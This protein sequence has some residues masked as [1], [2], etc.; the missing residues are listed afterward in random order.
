[1]VEVE[2]NGTDFDMQSPIANAPITDINGQTLK[3]T[4]I[5]ADEALI[6]DSASS[7]AVKRITLNSFLSPF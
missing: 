2:Y 5:G 7:F 4:P 1:M 6:A 3:A